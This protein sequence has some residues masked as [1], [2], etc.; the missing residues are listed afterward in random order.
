MIK[1]HSLDPGGLRL[2]A[3]L[4]SYRGAH[5][6]CFPSE[7]TLAGDL[8]VSEKTVQNWKRNLLKLGYLEQRTRK[9]RSNVYMVKF[10]EEA[11]RRSEGA[12]AQRKSCRDPLVALAGSETADLGHGKD[13]SMVG[14][15][16]LPGPGKP[17]SRE[18]GSS[19]PG[20]GGSRVPPK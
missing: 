9:G 18:G 11:K 14:R 2:L 13:T 16:E 1:D 12:T 20:G 10:P 8:G 19:L 3:L 7:R 15:Q 5:T 4:L 17:V 6:S